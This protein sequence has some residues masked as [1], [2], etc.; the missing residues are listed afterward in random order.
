MKK[1]IGVAV[2]VMLVNSVVLLS[3][4]RALATDTTTS[5]GNLMVTATINGKLQ[6]F[7]SPWAANVAGV[8]SISDPHPDTSVP[9]TMLGTEA[10][11]QFGRGTVSGFS[12]ANLD[13]TT[14]SGVP[15][16]QT[17]INRMVSSG[18]GTT[19]VNQLQTQINQ[20]QGQAGYT[21][22]DKFGVTSIT[23]SAGNMVGQA[24]GTLV[25]TIQ[26]ATSTGVRT[27]TCTETFT[28][29]QNRDP[30]TGALVFYS[31]GSAAVTSTI[32]TK[33][34][35]GCPQMPGH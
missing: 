7:G 8:Q 5:S 16:F 11:T 30:V 6:P 26:Q 29:Q 21:F 1:T 2:L 20:T 14:T 28:V 3:E 19:R 4:N 31:D 12:Q 22:N 27:L 33:S 13:D 35:D 32:T 15:D 9:K 25:Q 23:D 17:V 10:D 24:S 34:G 18:S